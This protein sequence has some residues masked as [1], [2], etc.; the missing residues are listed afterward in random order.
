MYQNE[1]QLYLHMWSEFKF[2]CEHKA[3]IAD[4]HINNKGWQKLKE[5]HLEEYLKDM[6]NPYGFLFKIRFRYK[7]VY[8]EVHCMPRFYYKYLRLRKKELDSPARSVVQ[9]PTWRRNDKTHT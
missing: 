8:R 4:C 5:Y 1:V 3:K 2:C 6:D 9:F 7:D